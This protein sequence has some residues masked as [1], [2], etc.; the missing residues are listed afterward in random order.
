MAW[1]QYRDAKLA[2]VDEAKTAVGRP[3]W[4]AAAWALAKAFP[5]D[6]GRSGGTARPF[7]RLRASGPSGTLRDSGAGSPAAAFPDPEQWLEMCGPTRADF[8]ALIEEN[9]ALPAEFRGELP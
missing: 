6:Y 3:N 5:E 8:G 1:E 2:I 9:E 4:R 7:D